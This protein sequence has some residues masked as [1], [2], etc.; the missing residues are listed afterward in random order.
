MFGRLYTMPARREEEDLDQKVA[1]RY[2]SSSENSPNLVK[3]SQK[4]AELTKESILAVLASDGVETNAIREIRLLDPVFH[5]WARAPQV[6]KLDQFQ[7]ISGTI[8]IDLKLEIEI[9]AHEDHSRP[10]R[11]FNHQLAS[12]PMKRT[13]PFPEL[14]VR[15]ISQS[16]LKQAFHGEVHAFDYDLSTPP[17]PVSN[18]S[19]LSL[20]ALAN[21]GSSK[22]IHMCALTQQPQSAPMLLQSNSYGPVNQDS[23]HLPLADLPSIDLALLHAAPLVW[24]QGRM[25]MP[26]DHQAFSLDFKGESKALNELLSRAGRRITLRLDV[27][28]A[29]S[30]AEVLALDPVILHL[31]CHGDID[32]SER[33]LFL[34]FEDSEGALDRLFLSRLEALL[35]PRNFRNG[36]RLVFVSACHSQSAAEKFVEYGVP[37]CV[38]VRADSKVL[39]DAASV[40]AQF[41]YYGLVQGETVRAA[42]ELGAATLAAA[43]PTARLPD[44]IGES[45]KFLLLPEWKV[46]ERD[47]HDVVL[48]PALPPGEI[49]E[50]NQ[51]SHLEPPYLQKPFLG[52]AIELRE[53]VLTL[54][55]KRQKEVRLVTLCGPAGVGKT[56]LAIAAAVYLFERRWFQDGCVC[57]EMKGKKTEQAALSALTDALD[58]NFRTLNDISRALRNWRG[59]ILLDECDAADADLMPMLLSKLMTT[60]ELRV[61]CTAREP[62]GFPGERIFTTKPLLKN[63]AARLFRELALEGLPSELRPHGALN[64]HPVLAAL[65]GMPEAIWRTAPLLRQGHTMN[66]LEL[67]LSRSRPGLL[68]ESVSAPN[69]APEEPAIPY[70]SPAPST[71]LATHSKRTPDI[72]ATNSNASTSFLIEEKANRPASHAEI[73][74]LQESLR[75]SLDVS[76]SFLRHS[77]SDA[78]HLLTVI[79]FLPGGALASDLDAI[80]SAI[81]PSLASTETT[82]NTASWKALIQVLVQP[83]TVDKG[84][85]LSTS[86]W[87]VS[88]KQIPTEGMNEGTSL[89]TLYQCSFFYDNESATQKPLLHLNSSQVHKFAAQ[90]AKHFARVGKDALH[91]LQRHGNN[92][93]PVPEVF[94]EHIMQNMWACLST[95]RIDILKS[96]SNIDASRSTADVGHALTQMLSLLGR[97]F[98]AAQAAERTLKACQIL[99]L[100]PDVIAE[101]NIL[102]AE[103]MLQTGNVT[104]AQA[105]AHEVVALLGGA[106]SVSVKN[107]LEVSRSQATISGGSEITDNARKGQHSTTTHTPSPLSATNTRSRSNTPLAEASNS[108]SISCQ[109]RMLKYSRV[110][111]RDNFLKK[112]VLPAFIVLGETHFCKALEALDKGSKQIELQKA[113]NFFNR[114]IRKL[115]EEAQS[116]DDETDFELLLSATKSLARITHHRNEPEKGIELLYHLGEKANK[117]PAVLALRGKCFVDMENYEAASSAFERA[118]ELYYQQGDGVHSQECFEALD[119]VRQQLRSTRVAVGRL[120]V[121]HAAP[122]VQRLERQSIDNKVDPDLQPVAFSKRL[123]LRA[124]RSLYASLK[125]LK[126]AI[127]VQF[128]VGTFESF[129]SVLQQEHHPMLHFLPTCSTMSGITLEG[130]AGMRETLH[131]TD[132]SIMLASARCIPNLVFLSTNRS[133][134]AGRRFLEAGCSVV[135]AIQGFLEE[136][137]MTIFAETFYDFLLSRSATPGHAFSAA[138]QKMSEFASSANGEFVLLLSESAS[139]GTKP[140][141]SYVPHEG[142]IVDVSPKRCATNLPFNNQDGVTDVARTSLRGRALSN[143]EDGLAHGAA[144]VGRRLELHKLVQACLENRLIAVYG[145][146]GSGKSALLLEAARFLRHRG[147]FPHGIFCCSLK[148]MR[149]MKKV[150]AHIGSAL[151]FPTRSFDDLFKFMSQ[152]SSAL[153]ILD[154]C[155]A[156]INQSTPQFSWFL[157]DVLNAGVQ[158]V[159]ASQQKMHFPHGDDEHVVTTS[160]NELT[161]PPMS[162]HDS[163]LLLLELCEREIKAEELGIE[164]GQVDSLAALRRHPLLKKLGGRPSTIRW[165]ARQLFSQ[166][167]FDLDLQIASLSPKEQARLVNQSQPAAPELAPSH[168][169]TTEDSNSCSRRNSAVFCSCSRRNSTVFSSWSKARDSFTS[170]VSCESDEATTEARKTGSREELSNDV[171][172]RQISRAGSNRN[173]DRKLTRSLGEMRKLVELA[174]SAVENGEIANEVEIQQ[175]LERLQLSLFGNLGRRQSER[176]L[177]RNGSNSLGRYRRERKASWVDEEY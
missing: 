55:R 94:L 48:F 28:S 129:S 3:R 38:G 159:I 97:K 150:R 168:R 138:K 166:S 67:D 37:H 177:R 42:F 123:G 101:Q 155:E 61:L 85:Q 169:A 132:L 99:D 100:A 134:D 146:V 112:L 10:S 58:M 15:R 89:D 161:V 157:K 27:A 91:D 170:S 78:F 45:T 136:N 62:I 4:G 59:L 53:L 119:K 109:P 65:N 105:A 39:D 86:R 144:F 165:A 121:I 18:S 172:D 98:D 71:S 120:I 1:L 143:I 139:Q 66:D 126:L 74:E 57:I 7:S 96:R 14:E 73:F 167:L 102:L 160:L 151:N 11:P 116:A 64:D 90:C 174:E 128:E 148:G 2:V 115:K 70:D 79:S 122:L 110:H 54:G 75:R 175:S 33:A 164:N 5:A 156:A 163:A 158:V 171:T 133:L 19:Q 56:S 47:P 145:G 51:L 49:I 8:L 16:G 52:R 26:L 82:P 72:E 24:R 81:A 88:Q 111:P 35:S 104:A 113:E 77:H 127:E 9:Y 6:I 22:Q 23:S 118:A 124:W 44:P 140:L 125:A 147:H 92:D 106:D 162:T 87:L 83:D 34:G 31:V 69:A 152:F 50:R 40:F 29:S 13:S 17:G 84:G 93:T 68:D 63:D 20:E 154:R 107:L 131:L 142:V 43:T 41:M 173:F 60:Q 176:Q 46:G 141:H 76:I 36:T 25:L 114:V 32:P 108:S 21:E 117:I 153:L 80:W 95:L 135:I 30:L 130:K 149:N 12:P 103:Q 137:A